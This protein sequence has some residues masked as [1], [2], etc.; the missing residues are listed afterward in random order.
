MSL[1]RTF[2]I[3]MAFIYQAAFLDEPVVWTSILGAMIVCIGVSLSCLKKLYEVRPDKFNWLF[4]LTGQ[5]KP[6]DSDISLR[7]GGEKG[8]VKNF[9]TIS[10][11]S[12]CVSE[13]GMPSIV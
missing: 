3:V 2:D 9:R 7:T 8:D 10:L 1:A 6:V 11:V 5:V 13:N 12:N 4:R